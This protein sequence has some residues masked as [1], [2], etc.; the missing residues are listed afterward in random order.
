M[1]RV[2][3]C[4]DRIVLCNKLKRLRE[5]TDVI[6][7]KPGQRDHIFCSYWLEQNSLKSLASANQVVQE[8]LPV[9]KNLKILA[10]LTGVEYLARKMRWK[11]FG[12]CRFH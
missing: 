10:N 12:A 1:L 8:F 2:F 11:S 6:G 4:K 3:R 5:I 9:R 7:Y